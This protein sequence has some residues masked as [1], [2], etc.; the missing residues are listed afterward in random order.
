MKKIL[1]NLKNK[2]L[3]ELLKR[4][5][6]ENS[7]E[8]EVIDNKNFSKIDSNKY[9]LLIVDLDYIENNIYLDF[10]S[11]LDNFPLIINT[12]KNSIN[13]ELIKKYN[14]I[15]I[16]NDYLEKNEAK[17]I[18]KKIQQITSSL[19]SNY[20]NFEFT[21][22]KLF[23][24]LIE[25]NSSLFPNSIN[26]HPK[27]RH[28][29]K[30]LADKLDYPRLHE[31]NIASL[32]SNLGYIGVDQNII[33][34]V[35]NNENTTHNEITI[36]LNH[37]EI[38]YRLLNGIDN[39]E[40]IRN[41]IRYQN[42]YFDGRNSNEKIKGES[43]PVISRILLVVNDFISLQIKNSINEISALQI[44]SKSQYKY[45]PKCF[46][47]LLKEVTGKRNLK[48]KQNNEKLV[49]VLDDMST[50]N[51]LYYKLENIKD[52]MIIAEDV[53]DDF[54]NKVVKKGSKLNVYTKHFLKKMI[55]N[56]RIKDS[57]KVFV[58]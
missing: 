57:I 12:N 53:F 43:I 32:L 52:D 45:C 18:I 51:S 11:G 27:H 10:N 50:K 20:L 23:R 37:T 28:Y 22:K 4:N 5:L 36:F 3:A 7:F 19:N 39:I 26:F 30:I 41:G 46:S 56:N 58:D 25:I 1:I 21:Y 38:A 24:T 44:M 2:D 33:K 17:D 55:E 49:V 15:T 9:L 40:N 14:I 35:L 13:I 8:I 54:N 42:L 6:E 16:I 48:Q 29:C 34:K 47:F 31:I